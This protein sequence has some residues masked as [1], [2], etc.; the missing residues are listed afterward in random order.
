MIKK[1]MSFISGIFFLYVIGISATSLVPLVSREL[2]SITAGIIIV[3]IFLILMYMMSY[4]AG[5]AEKLLERF[6]DGNKRLSDRIFCILAMILIIF[7]L[8]FAFIQDFTPKNDLS[9]ICTGAENIVMGNFLYDNI[10]EI[11]K[12]YFAVYPNNHMI[13]TVISVLYRLEYL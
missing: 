1:Y 2:N 11:H 13:L 5:K 4:G 9:Y 10:P 6:I 8:N 12:H 3:F 7:Q